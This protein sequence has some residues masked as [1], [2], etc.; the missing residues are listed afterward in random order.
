MKPFE[1]YDKYEG[2]I[3]RC[4]YRKL[5]KDMKDM[6]E[7]GNGS[8]YAIRE[9]IRTHA[10]DEFAKHGICFKNNNRKEIKYEKKAEF[11]N[12]L[13]I[14]YERNKKRKKK[15][16]TENMN[17][18]IK[19]LDAI[20]EHRQVIEEIYSRYGETILRELSEIHMR[21]L[22]SDEKFIESLK[23]EKETMDLIQ[24]A[25]IDYLESEANDRFANNIFDK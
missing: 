8:Y 12:P 6:A 19:H 15:M 10:I 16:Y 17:A 24:C 20:G 23:T 5:S 1:I 9:A 2:G 18:Y 3:T 13:D 4:E 14:V 11:I 21:A 7:S 25:R 22:M